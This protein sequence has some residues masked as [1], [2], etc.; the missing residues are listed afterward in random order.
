MT[1]KRRTEIQEIVGTSQVVLSEG[2]SVIMP[3]VLVDNQHGDLR[4]NAPL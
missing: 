1:N 3:G 2:T 4:A